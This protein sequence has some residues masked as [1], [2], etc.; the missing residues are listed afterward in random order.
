MKIYI[1][2]SFLNGVQRARTEKKYEI[3]VSAHTSDLKFLYLV[4][5]TK[6]AKANVSTIKDA[7]MY[8][9]AKYHRLSSVPSDNMFRGGYIVQV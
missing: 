1:Y 2:T 9:R 4:L 3:L 6:T 8:F 5:V 7:V